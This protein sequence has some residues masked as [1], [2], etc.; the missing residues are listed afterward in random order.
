M[1]IKNTQAHITYTI[2]KLPNIV[3]IYIL[4]ILPFSHSLFKWK[5]GKQDPRT[6]STSPWS[7]RPHVDI[8]INWAMETFHPCSIPR[9]CKMFSP[10]ALLKALLNWKYATTWVFTTR[11]AF[12]VGSYLKHFETRAN[13]GV[14]VSKQRKNLKGWWQGWRAGRVFGLWWP[15]CHLQNNFWVW[16]TRWALI[17]CVYCKSSY[18]SASLFFRDYKIPTI[19]VIPRILMYTRYTTLEPETSMD[20]NGCFN[21]MIQSLTWEMAVSPNIRLKLVCLLGCPWKWS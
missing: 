12:L 1:Y 10:Q 13:W 16:P 20:F 14:L 19:A 21:W 3:I 6:I 11:L 2:P 15:F 7:H 5:N 8:I 4:Y 9:L 17:Q 18:I